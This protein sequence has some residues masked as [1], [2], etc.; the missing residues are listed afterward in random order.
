MDEL[1]KNITPITSSFGFIYGDINSITD[2]FVS[3]QS[4][5]LKNENTLKKTIKTDNL[6][7]T[8]LELCP[9]TTVERRKYLFIS[10]KNKWVA[11]FDN[12][13]TGTD[14]G[15]IEIIGKKLKTKSIF[16]SY[17]HDTNEVLF[18]YYNSGIL[19]RSI[20]LVKEGKWIFQQY[21]T[22]F[23]FENPDYYKSRISKNKFNLDILIEYL[24]KIKIEAYDNKY[25]TPEKEAI[26]IEKNG[27]MFEA[28]KEL[29]LK[30]AK[31]YYS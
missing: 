18:E 10:T 8:F 2:E 21:G 26:L 4:P 7:N 24:K 16:I 25:Y 28:T 19:E 20:S 27:P 17:K 12:G 13:H 9:L 6:E 3:W 30:E 5:L 29:N 15:S 31:E 11:F 22:P 14:R 1:F 23:S